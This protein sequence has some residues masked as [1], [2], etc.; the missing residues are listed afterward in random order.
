MINN[1]RT[2][3]LYKSKRC[4]TANK[5]TWKT[6]VI[7]FIQYLTAR[8]SDPIN[9]RW[10]AKPVQPALLESCRNPSM[11][12]VS[13]N[14]FPGA[15][16]QLL[17]QSP[18]GGEVHMAPQPGLEDSPVQLKTLT[19]LIA[20]ARDWQ[21]QVDLGRQLK[22]PEYIA[23]TTL[24]PV[25]V[26]SSIS[27]ERKKAKYQELI[28]ICRGNG[29]KARCEPIEVGCRR[30]PGQSLHRALRLLG[31]RGLQERKATN[32]IC[33]AAERAS[34]WL[35]IKRGDPWCSMLTMDQR[36]ETPND[37]GS[38]RVQ[39]AHLCGWCYL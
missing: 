24:R 33:E 12:T 37:P 38:S 18:G 27:H 16:F 11:P 7:F 15:H 17:T 35:W 30:F 20:S 19:G 25:L 14:G 28:E 5:Q 2:E 26:L 8:L 34:M 1:I 21:L 6:T 4:K 23:T 10:P 9:G 3:V 39:A 32:N 36:P 29:W 31:T 13:A 22:F